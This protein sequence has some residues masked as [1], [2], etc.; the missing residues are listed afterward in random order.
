MMDCAFCC[1]VE[2]FALTMFIDFLA[3][4]ASNTFIHGLVQRSSPRTH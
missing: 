4:V 1:M 2:K 3:C